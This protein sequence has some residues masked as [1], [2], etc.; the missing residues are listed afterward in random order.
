MNRLSAAGLLIASTG[1]MT[2]CRGTIPRSSG[3]P[4]QGTSALVIGSRVILPSGDTYSGLMVLNLEGESGGRL[5]EI[6]RLPVTPKRPT[7]F[8]VEPGT[9]RL[10]P[11][12]SLFGFHQPL[13]KVDIEGAPYR[14]PF[15]RDILRRPPIEVRAGRAAVIGLLEARV[16][17]ARPGEDATVK[18]RLDD[19]ISTRRRLVED[20]IKDMMDPAKSLSEREHSIS[21]SRALHTALLE[22]SAETERLPL[23]KSS[24]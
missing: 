18:V 23:Y 1:L 13:L 9:Y 3:E 10:A 17:P 16:S 6:Y 5:A 7:I 2:A 8:Q 4:N 12:R 15:P 14:V 21:W 20:I 11:S 19:A 24:P 22:I